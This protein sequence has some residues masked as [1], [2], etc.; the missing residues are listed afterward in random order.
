MS[1]LYRLSEFLSCPNH[2]FFLSNATKTGEMKS[3]VLIFVVV[4]TSSA[5]ITVIVQVYLH[6]VHCSEKREKKADQWVVL[7]LFHIK[8]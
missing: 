2:A 7:G 8:M 6:P 4:V 5:H 3:G 1:C